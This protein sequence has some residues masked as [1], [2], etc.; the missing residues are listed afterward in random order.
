MS[1]SQPGGVA[2][3][4]PTRSLAGTPRSPLPPLLKLRRTRRSACVAKAGRSRGSLAAL[5]RGVVTAVMVSV[6]FAACGG[7]GG[8][9]SGGGGGTTPPPTPNPTPANPCTTALLADTS[10]VS[11]IR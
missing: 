4:P 11:A 7:G 10:D 9:N 3:G 6:I 1:H 2:A 5:V 8:G